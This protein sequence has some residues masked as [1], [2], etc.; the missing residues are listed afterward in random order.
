[1]KNAVKHAKKKTLMMFVIFD[2]AGRL[3]IDDELMLGIKG[4][5]RKTENRIRYI[6]YVI[7][8]IYGAGCR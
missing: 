4:D 6:L 1:M 2:T 8:S 7:S 3:H 5:Q